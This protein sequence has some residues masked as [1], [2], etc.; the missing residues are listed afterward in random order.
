MAPRL[1]RAEA[2]L[3]RIVMTFDRV[4]QYM[5]PLLMLLIVVDV[6]GRRLF[7]LP[8][9]SFQEG[10][11]HVHGILFLL[12]LGGTYLRNGHVRVEI[13]SERMS[14]RV[15][16]VIEVLGCLLLVL[17]YLVLVLWFGTQFAWESFLSGDRSSAAEGL[18]HRWIIKSFVPIGTLLLILA[19][20]AIIL[21]SLAAL[22]EGRE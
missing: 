18:G 1:A 4:G 21:R 9:V 10:E 5:F 7:S 13:L 12:T 16:L 14:P 3:T 20:L 22:R 15:R 6:V 19:T 2:A 8:T 17:P 11:W